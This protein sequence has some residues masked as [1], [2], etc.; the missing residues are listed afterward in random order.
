MMGA[1]SGAGTAYPSRAPENEIIMVAMEISILYI[2]N[3]ICLSA[4]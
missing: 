4:L 2:N 1:T 3:I